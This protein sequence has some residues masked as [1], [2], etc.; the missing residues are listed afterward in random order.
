LKETLFR[1]LIF[2]TL[3]DTDRWRQAMTVYDLA[4]IMDKCACWR[5]GPVVSL[6]AIS[7]GGINK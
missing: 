6:C 2:I 3:V 1:R 4:A 5:P 7:P